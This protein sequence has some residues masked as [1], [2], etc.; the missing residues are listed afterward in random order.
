M[1]E[2]KH[3]VRA[4]FAVANC[5][6]V[7]LL[8]VTCSPLY[9][10]SLRTAVTLIARLCRVFVSHHVS[11]LRPRKRSVG[12]AGGSFSFSALHRVV[13]SGHLPLAQETVLVRYDVNRVEVERLTGRQEESRAWQRGVEA[14]FALR[15]LDKMAYRRA[16]GGHPIRGQ[17]L[18]VV[19]TSI[20]SATRGPACRHGGMLQQ[21]GI[22]T[23]SGLL[24]LSA[25]RP[26]DM[27]RP[28]SPMKLCPYIS[29]VGGKPVLGV[30]EGCPI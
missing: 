15:Q 20:H 30:S 10:W 3:P 27:L 7:P 6:V 22:V 14:A 1:A 21:E 13:S 12:G 4:V 23:R 24:H 16:E 17:R 11:V 19:T 26:S 29:L 8:L 25:A 5:R 18:R 2:S 28:K 9:L